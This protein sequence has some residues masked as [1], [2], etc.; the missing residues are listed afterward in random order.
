MKSIF[1]A[2]ALVLEAAMYLSGVRD[3]ESLDPQL[4]ERLE[5]LE[6]SP[7]RIN[8]PGSSARG[9]L[10]A[11]QLA[12]LED[13][14]GRCGDIL[15]WEELA[16][17]DGFGKEFVS[18]MRPFL[19]LESSSAPGSRDTTRLKGQALVR[20]A[21]NGIGGKV[22]AGMGPYAAS[23]AIRG[24]DWTASASA[25][26][27]RW[28]VVAGDFNIRY[29]QGAALWTGFAIESLETV[30]SYMRKPS[31]ITPVCSFLP[32]EN[33]GAAVSYSRGCFCA[34]AF[35][36]LG[37]LYG[38]HGSW[39]SLKGELGLT[40]ALDG[41]VT[42]VSTDGRLSTKAGIF[43]W[44]MGLRGK[45]P[46]GRFSWLGLSGQW[47]FAFQGR[48]LPTS[49]TGESSGNYGLAGGAAWSS[50]YGPGNHSLSL[51]L[52]ASLVPKPRNDP[53][54]R[55]LRLYLDWTWQINQLW[56]MQARLSGRYRNWEPSRTGLRLDARYEG[57]AWRF[58]AK[59]EGCYCD[60]PG[61]LLYLEGCRRWKTLE[62]YA[63]IT[64]FGTAGWNSRIYCWQR[65]APG[66]FSVPAYSGLGLYPQVYLAWKKRMG[67]CTFK[68]HAKASY[69]IK[70]GKKPAPGFAVQI[71]VSL[72]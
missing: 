69:M 6:N 39:L 58:A 71:S 72:P 28:S 26:I 68:A 51:S 44:E 13:Y 35:A 38:C 5:A 18:V 7:I 2:V 55:Q 8:S 34:D 17:V 52:D 54:R 27:S 9:I 16:L 32:S 56:K 11:Y 47:N 36:T 15:S 31:G 64:A 25:E 48:Y 30:Q 45:A 60:G 70:R 19:S 67:P 62:A 37:R 61:G 42:L 46:G 20:W 57:V 12:S 43:A 63:E 23:V 66:T 59:A 50:G 29:G 65:D 24:K 10:S 4:I 14:R 40:A 21:G 41:G 33:R 53:S 22:K 1:M 49:F 3:E